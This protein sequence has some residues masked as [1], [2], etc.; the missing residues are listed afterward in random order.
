MS[1]R[2]P[3]IS[4]VTP[5]LNQGQFLE[6]AMGSV[7]KQGYP[8]LEYVVVDG[9]SSDG[10]VEIIEKYQDHLVYW[11]SE[12]DQ[13]Q[14]HAINK[15]FAHTSGEIMAWLNSD[16][17]FMPSAFSIVAD[18][19]SSYP[20]VEWITTI[21]PLTWNIK[22][23]AVAV[24]FTGGFHPQ[25]FYKGSNLPA[26][27]SFGRRWIQQE[28]T[29]WRRSLWERAGGQL[30]PTFKLA[31]DFELWARFFQHANLYGVSALLGGFRAHGNQKSMEFRQAYMAEAEMILRRYGQWP[32]QFGEGLVRGMLWKLARQ[33]SLTGLPNWG[34]NAIRRVPW[35]YPTEVLVWGGKEWEFITGFV[36]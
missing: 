10:S 32:C 36:V 7:L 15:G 28:S 9:G 21:H 5:S 24:D 34:R 1:D 12:A 19:F 29:F 18:I 11:V 26:K 20:E 6:E 8:R 23:Q 31:A 35:F 3:L 4:I 13:G 30:D 22:G 25:A 2:R 27:G 33:Y 17:K 14:Y 16:D